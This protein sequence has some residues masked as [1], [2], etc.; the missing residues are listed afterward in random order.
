MFIPFLENVKEKTRF[1]KGFII[2]NQFLTHIKRP[3]ILVVLVCHGP[4]G[5]N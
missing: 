1:M 5:G 4:N 3:T 2:V